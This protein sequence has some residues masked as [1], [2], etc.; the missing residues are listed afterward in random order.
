[1]IELLLLL[2]T[3]TPVPAVTPVCLLDG[4]GKQ[5]D[6]KLSFEDFDQV[7]TLPLTWRKLA[8]AGCYKEAIA[9]ISDYLINGPVLNPKQQRVL[10]FHLGQMLA[11]NGEERR[12]ADFV[13]ASREPLGERSEADKLNWN[14]YV[15]GTWAFLMK[16]R[17]FLIRSRDAVLAGG[18]RNAKNAAFLSGLER[19]FDKPYSVAYN[20]NCGKEPK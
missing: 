12:A 18:T 9:A 20:Q 11:F 7:G 14:D 6:A 15:A 10:L 1:M 3:A 13:A 5:A 16:D 4:S 8:E 2:A 19:C 17:K